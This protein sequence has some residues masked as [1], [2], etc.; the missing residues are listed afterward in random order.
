MLKCSKITPLDIIE[1]FPE[2]PRCHS[3]RV[4][5]LDKLHAGW[6][7]QPWHQRT[8]FK[9]FLFKAPQV[10]GQYSDTLNTILDHAN[11]FIFCLSRCTL[12]DVPSLSCHFYLVVIKQQQQHPTGFSFCFLP[13]FLAIF[14]LL[15][16]NNFMPPNSTPRRFPSHLFL[17]LITFYL[18]RCTLSDFPSV[19]YMASLPFLSCCHRTS[20][21]SRVLVCGFLLFLM[22]DRVSSDSLKNLWVLLDCVGSPLTVKFVVTRDRCSRIF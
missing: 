8:F 21:E 20:T 4:S 19:S 15:S 17:T 14:I 10:I 22:E 16:S 2:T 7:L 11:L 1:G 12:P 18:P 6:F 13:G 5:Q 9:H 3:S